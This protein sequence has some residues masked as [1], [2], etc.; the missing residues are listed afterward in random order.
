VDLVIVII[1]DFF[2]FNIN[3][4]LILDF[5]LTFYYY[6]FY[7]GYFFI[8]KNLQFHHYCYIYISDLFFFIVI[9]NIDKFLNLIFFLILFFNIKLSFLNNLNSGI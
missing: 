8:K 6:L 9:F 1:I 7:F 4:F 3:F 2:L 5:F